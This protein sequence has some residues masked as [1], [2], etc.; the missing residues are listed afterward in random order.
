[1]KP[2]IAKYLWDLNKGA[3]KEVPKILRNPRHP[4]FNER[5]VAILSRCDKPKELFSLIS[6]REFME[7]WP[8]VRKYW[9]KVARMSDFRDWWQA[10]Y[11]G[12]LEKYRIKTTAQSKGTPSTLLLKIGKTIREARIAKGLSQRELASM[13][14]ARQPDISMIEDGK[15]NITLYTLGRLSKALGI[16]KIS[17]GK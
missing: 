14:K 3:L 7:A 16:D 2:N 12:L 9:F 17:L 10:I 1:M 6:D 4:R 11:E 13:I 8:A 15:K 5:M